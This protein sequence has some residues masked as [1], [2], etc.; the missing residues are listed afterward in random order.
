MIMPL[1]TKLDWFIPILNSDEEQILLSER[2]GEKNGLDVALELLQKS[3]RP[4]VKVCLHLE[5]INCYSPVLN[6]VGLSQDV[7]TSSCIMALAISAH[8][9]GHSLQPR[10]ILM[11]GEYLKNSSIIGGM[12]FY[13]D[14]IIIAPAIYKAM[15]AWLQVLH[16]EES[17][18]HQTPPKT[19][20]TWIMRLPSIDRIIYI[21]FGSI[22]ELIFLPVKLLI[23]M[24]SG[25]VA[26]I[27]VC[28]SLLCSYLIFFGELQASWI[29]LRLLK[30]HKYLNRREY[31]VTRKFLFAC[32]LTYLR[33]FNIDHV[34]Q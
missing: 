12:S 29:G 19:R 7:A 28:C 34:I 18:R 16:K 24:L 8:E 9:V 14:V 15:F 10:F 3:N 20:R 13:G 6:F 22:V 11:I 5:E 23:S 32:A 17:E 4:D 33:A 2:L 26:M 21:I 30:Q 31:N 27:A 25:I 1:E